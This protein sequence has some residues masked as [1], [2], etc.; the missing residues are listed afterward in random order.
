MA[1]QEMSDLVKRLR[2]FEGMPEAQGWN[3]IEAADRIEA[4]E[5][6]L[7]EPTIV[8]DEMV[9]AGAKA[10]VRLGHDHRTRGEPMPTRLQEARACLIAHA[11][12]DKDTGQ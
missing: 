12:L 10:M 8:T 7:R 11:A 1:M 6:A 3:M 4:L 5:A 2:N 9:M